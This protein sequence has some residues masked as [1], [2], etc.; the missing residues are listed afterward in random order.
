MVTDTFANIIY[1]A[2]QLNDVLIASWH[3]HLMRIYDHP[4][5]VDH[6]CRTLVVLLIFR[7]LLKI[8]D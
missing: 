7:Y 5:S 6:V 2:L 3:A 1:H 4:L 8:R